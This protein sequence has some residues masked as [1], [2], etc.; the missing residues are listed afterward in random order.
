[1]IISLITI[2]NNVN[3]YPGRKIVT[4]NDICMMGMLTQLA[5]KR[6]KGIKVVEE[7]VFQLCFKLDQTFNFTK[8]QR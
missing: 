5:Y 4:V 6:F 1:M 8:I 2:D 7:I 3:H